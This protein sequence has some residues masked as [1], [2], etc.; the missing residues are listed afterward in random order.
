MSLGSIVSDGVG[1]LTGGLVGGDPFGLNQSKD[2]GAIAA[3][4]FK[5]RSDIG[6]GKFQNG[7]ITSKLSPELQALFDTQLDQGADQLAGVPD[8]GEQSLGL[9]EGFLSE[10]G[11]FDPFAAAEEQ[12]TRLDSILEGGRS[13]S[14][15]GQ[16][17]GLL[18]TGRLG[19]TSGNDAQAAVEGQIEQQ[20]QQLL[21]D[22]FESAQRTQQGLVDRGVQTGAFG[23]QQQ[24]AQQNLGQQSIS[25]AFGID[26]QLQSQLALGGQL[27]GAV[28]TTAPEKGFMENAATGFF[29]NI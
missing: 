11:S 29:S 18:A 22:S 6:K 7:K 8:A 16:A 14:R 9:S 28:G 26:S 12:F 1:A 15:T 21:G 20:R 5:T 27:S 23:M 25:G 19:G 10:V 2:A 17:G 4:P 24:A 3:L 13:R